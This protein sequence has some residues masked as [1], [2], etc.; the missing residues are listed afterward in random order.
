METTTF[1]VNRKKRIV[2]ADPETPLIYVLTNNLQ[3]KGT[4]LGCSLEQC[5]ACAVLVNGEKTLSCVKYFTEFEGDDILTIEGL[6]SDEELKIIQEAFI[7]EN[8]AQCGYCTSGIIIALASLFKKNKKPSEREF[9]E[10][11]NIHLC[12]CGS[13]P[14]VMKAF[15]SLVIN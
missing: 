8:A 13:H 5:G 6:N 12:R 14:Q 3:L 4:K 11:L 10:E 1:T 2:K 9:V 15:R 7:E